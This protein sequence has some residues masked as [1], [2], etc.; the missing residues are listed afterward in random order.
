M[1]TSAAGAGGGGWGGM[2]GS[3]TR[4][5]SVDT[6]LEELDLL[7]VGESCSVQQHRHS[8][9]AGGMAG[10]LDGSVVIGG[11]HRAEDERCSS[12]QHVRLR[13]PPP[14]CHRPSWPGAPGEHR[15]P[16]WPACATPPARPGWPPGQP[17]SPAVASHALEFR[18]IERSVIMLVHASVSGPP[19]RLGGC[20]SCRLPCRS[21]VLVEQEGCWGIH[22]QRE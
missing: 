8:V 6:S 7:R 1:P 3:M 4:P 10:C 17:C 5:D 2:E 21:C 13:C 12:T 15:S 20:M 22:L 16:A 9:S 19:A 18:T 14:S 11:L